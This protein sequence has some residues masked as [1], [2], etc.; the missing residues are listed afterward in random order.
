LLRQ[1]ILAHF[2]DLKDHERRVRVLPRTESPEDHRARYGSAHIALDPFPYSGTTTSYEALFMG[3]PIITLVGERHVQRTTY[4]LLKNVGVEEG[5]AISEKEYLDKAVSLAR[6]RG[7]LRDVKNKIRA[8]VRRPQHSAKAYTKGLERAYEM[9][10]DAYKR[11]LKPRE[12]SV[13]PAHCLD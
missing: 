8:G 4:S 13:P 9:M 7:E 6:D 5:I 1:N 12:L 10:W 2:K 11:K 3:V